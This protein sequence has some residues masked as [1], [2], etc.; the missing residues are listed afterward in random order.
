[1]LLLFHKSNQLI[2]RIYVND[3]NSNDAVTT[4]ELQLVLAVPFSA[5]IQPIIH[6]K[7]T[8]EECFMVSGL[9]LQNTRGQ[10]L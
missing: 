6:S 5:L 9:Y 2:G 4:A 10:R 7:K 3:K 8:K 1:L